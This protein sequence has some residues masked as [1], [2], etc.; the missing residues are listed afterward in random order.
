MTFRIKPLWH[1]LWGMVARDLRNRYLGSFGGKAWNV[2]YPL[3]M[4]LIYTL[5]FSN[6]IHANFPAIKGPFGYA[7]Y[8]CSG[9]LPW[10][11]LDDSLKRSTPALVSNISLIQNLPFPREILVLQYVISSTVTLCISLVILLGLELSAGIE[12]Q[13]D[14][15][16]LL[17]LIVL[18]Q[19]LLMLGP[20]LVLSVLHVYMR[21]T[22]Q[23]V[24]VGLSLLFWL[25]PVVY[26]PHI[27]PEWAASVVKNNPLSHLVALYRAVLL[28]HAFRMPAPEHLATLLGLTALLLIVGIVFFRRLIRWVPDDL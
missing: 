10:L 6:I 21:D 20:A 12:L 22:E 14:R 25:I 8:L 13:P 24:S 11:A 17:P 7:M 15:L 3:L 16:L 19:V 2:L 28:P 18:L 1:L 23:L 26:V 27:L 4:I 5:V 9:L